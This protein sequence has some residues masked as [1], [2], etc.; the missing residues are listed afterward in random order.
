MRVLLVAAM[1]LV[2]AGCAEQIKPATKHAPTSPDQVKLYRKAPAQYEELGLIRVPVGGDVKWDKQG[3]ANAGFAQFRQK[4]AAM[5]A[6]GV[7]LLVPPGVSDAQVTAGDSGTFYAVPMKMGEPREA[8]A[9]AI[10]V[11]KP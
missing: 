10:F 6:N 7:L 3:N 2:L 1:A 8:V 5:G 11:I 9:Q 4:A